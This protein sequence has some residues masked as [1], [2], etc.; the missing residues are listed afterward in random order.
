[1]DGIRIFKCHYL[2]QMKLWEGSVFTGVCLF[3]GGGLPSHNAMGRI[4]VTFM[5][6]R[7]GDRYKLKKPYWLCII[8]V[9]YHILGIVVR[10]L[11][12]GKSHLTT[13]FSCMMFP[14]IIFLARHNGAS[15]LKSIIWRWF[16]LRV[17]SHF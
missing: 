13:Y 12:S 4:L 17:T 6:G 7:G 5:Y 10:T 16:S 1:M 9:I 8:F 2:L 14:T 11:R 15:H 3:T